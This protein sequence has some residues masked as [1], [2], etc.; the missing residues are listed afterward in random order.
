MLNP[1]SVTID[2]TGLAAN[3]SSSTHLNVHQDMLCTELGDTIPA[4]GTV[5]DQQIVISCEII[6]CFP[7]ARITAFMA[8]VSSSA[9]LNVVEI[10]SRIS[11][12]YR[13]KA[14]DKFRDSSNIN[15]VKF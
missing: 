4:I 8:N 1:N 5:L 9:G 2:T 6:V 3:D 14:S 11:Q 13:T 15:H 12:A 10:H 7:T